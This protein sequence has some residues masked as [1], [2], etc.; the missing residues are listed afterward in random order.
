MFG[1]E[2]GSLFAHIADDVHEH[3]P[4]GEIVW[5]H[6]DQVQPVSASVDPLIVVG[7]ALVVLAAAAFG[8]YRLMATRPTTAMRSTSA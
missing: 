7:A 4:N 2:A 5:H 3:T 6:M 1:F 8:A